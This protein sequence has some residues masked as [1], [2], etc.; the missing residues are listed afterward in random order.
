M[1][2][3][4]LL[5]LWGLLKFGGIMIGLRLAAKWIYRVLDGFRD[6]R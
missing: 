3:G 4:T 5:L 2:D 6:I 1:S